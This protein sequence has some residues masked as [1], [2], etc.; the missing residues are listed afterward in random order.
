MI[1]GQVFLGTAVSDI[2]RHF[3]VQADAMIGYSLGESAGLVALGAWT[4]RDEMIRRMNASS[5]FADELVGECR[6]A[7]KT[8]KIPEDKEVSWSVGFLPSSFTSIPP[9]P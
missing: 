7:R 1:V 3:G 2:V 5:I 4:D 8:W 9:R 6:S